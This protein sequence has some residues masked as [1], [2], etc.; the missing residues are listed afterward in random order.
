M[1]FDDAIEVFKEY[2]IV[3]VDQHGKLRLLSKILDDI[4]KTWS[5]GLFK[6]SDSYKITEASQSLVYHYKNAGLYLIDDNNE[7]LDEFLKQFNR[8]EEDAYRK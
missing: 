6:V 8:S 7:L 2:D 3:V 1:S 4:N 5:R